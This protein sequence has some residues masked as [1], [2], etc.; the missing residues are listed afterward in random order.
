MK[1]HEVYL[2]TPHPD[3]QGMK[4]TSPEDSDPQPAPPPQPPTK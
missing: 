3:D 4:G 2:T 1:V